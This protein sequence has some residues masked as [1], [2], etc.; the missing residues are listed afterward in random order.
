M[1]S[2]REAIDPSGNLHFDDLF[3]KRDEV[4]SGSEATI[5]RLSRLYAF[6]KILHHN[7]PIVLNSFRSED[8]STMKESVVFSEAV[9]NSV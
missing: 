3:T 9:P 8:R 6:S 5:F 7:Y 1:N 4:Y 2:V